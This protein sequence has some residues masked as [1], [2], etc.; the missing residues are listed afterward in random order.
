MITEIISSDKCNE[1]LKRILFVFF[2][3]LLWCIRCCL[4]PVCWTL[5]WSRSRPVTKFAWSSHICIARKKTKL[6]EKSTEE[7][8]QI[9]F[10]TL[11]EMKNNHIFAFRN[12]HLKQSRNFVLQLFLSI[13]YNCIE[14]TLHCSLINE[15]THYDNERKQQI[16][17]TNSVLWFLVREY[18]VSG[19][20]RQ[21]CCWTLIGAESVI[22]PLIG[23]WGTIYF[24]QPGRWRQ[25]MNII[26]L[27]LLTSVT[28]RLLEL[29]V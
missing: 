29:Q 24:P 15:S 25:I 9:I 12:E 1:L 5:L 13:L 28:G 2:S 21:L 14:C 18:W 20:V 22:S 10:E 4:S 16:F 6:S 17:N 19:N 11:T 27:W 26:S 7:F 8:D 3:H 23:Q